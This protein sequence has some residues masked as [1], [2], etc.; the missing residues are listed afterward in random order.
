M[1]FVAR[2]T[3]FARTAFCAAAGTGFRRERTFER[4]VDRFLLVMAGCP[5][6]A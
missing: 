6:A 4:A 2:M 5:F 1:T 3:F